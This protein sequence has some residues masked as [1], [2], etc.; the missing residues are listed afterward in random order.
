MNSREKQ[1][2]RRGAARLKALGR[3]GFSPRSDEER[4]REAVQTLRNEDVYEAAAA[5]EACE[6]SRKESGDATALCA[7]HLARAMTV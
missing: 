6:K 3:V 2:A 5:C 1:E 7:E 4:L